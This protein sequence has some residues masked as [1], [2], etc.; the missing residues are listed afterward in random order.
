MAVCILNKGASC[1]IAMN[2]S[3]SVIWEIGFNRRFPPFAPSF[4]AISFAA[5]KLFNVLLVVGS[6]IPE[7]SDNSLADIACRF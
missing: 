7:Y 3:K 6:G 2:I 4:E 1:S 5:F